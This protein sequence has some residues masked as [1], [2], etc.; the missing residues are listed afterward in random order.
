M[1][2][3]QALQAAQQVGLSS[4][5]CVYFQNDGSILQGA[6][7][8]SREVSGRKHYDV[9]KV[10]LDYAGNYSVDKLHEYET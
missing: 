10:C 3:D 6:H 1:N 8:H 9:W 5:E 2:R 4:G 7:Y